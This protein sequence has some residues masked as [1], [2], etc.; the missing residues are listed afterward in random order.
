MHC[1][2]ACDGEG[3]LYDFKKDGREKTKRKNAKIPYID[4]KFCY[5]WGVD[6]LFRVK[7]KFLK[8][9][10]PIE[11]VDF[12]L[13]N[14]ESKIN[15]V[16]ASQK[17]VV[18]GE[19]DCNFDKQTK[20]YKCEPS[21]PKAHDLVPWKWPSAS[22]GYTDCHTET[23]QFNFTSMDDGEEFKCMSC[24]DTM[25]AISDQIENGSFEEYEERKRRGVHYNGG[26]N[27]GGGN[28]YSSLYQLKC[29]DGKVVAKYRCRNR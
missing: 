29:D 10:G 12:S 18:N 11:C 14:C 8:E 25:A 16:L 19:W 22:F 6:T 20:E 23:P 28:N 5:G 9:K 21:C 4:A 7:K 3:K 2:V 26:G 17:P 13:G 1:E 24:D 15:E 27:G